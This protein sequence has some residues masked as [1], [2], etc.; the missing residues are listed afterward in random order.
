MT[1]DPVFLGIVMP[2]FLVL[3][4]ASMV[5]VWSATPMHT[6]FPSP[7]RV[8][9]QEAQEQGLQLAWESPRQAGASEERSAA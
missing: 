4:F 7:S 9:E 5:I 2:I 3:W 6:R 8:A 1:I